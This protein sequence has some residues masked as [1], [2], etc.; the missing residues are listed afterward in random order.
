M[1]FKEGEKF[2]NHRWMWLWFHYPS[3]SRGRSFWTCPSSLRSPSFHGQKF[4]KS[5]KLNVTMVF[6][7][8]TKKFVP[9]AGVECS[10]RMN[11]FW[12]C[13]LVSFT[14]VHE[15][16]RV[17]PVILHVVKNSGSGSPVPII[18]AKT[19]NGLDAVHREEVTFFAGSLLLLQVFI[20]NRCPS[21]HNL[22]G[23]L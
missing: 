6:K 1:D 11:S 15:T 12:L 4:C 19:F 10:Y 17:D 23:F 5:G 13:I 14:L 21:F 8:Y 7:Y 20:P 22:A 18:L 3:Y 16:P 9:F 2:N